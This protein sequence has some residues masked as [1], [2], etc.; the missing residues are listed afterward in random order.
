[1]KLRINFS[2]DSDAFSGSNPSEVIR[3]TLDTQVQK[4]LEAIDRVVFAKRHGK[5]VHDN[6]EHLLMRDENGNIIGSIAV[7]D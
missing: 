5:D 2:L 6:E 4:H 1:M 3:R 7:L